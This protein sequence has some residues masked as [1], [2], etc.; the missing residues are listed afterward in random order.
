MDKDKPTTVAMTD[1]E[2][3][4]KGFSIAVVV[5][6]LFG[7][8]ALTTRP[9]LSRN[10]LIV[11]GLLSF[12]L[13]ALY[14]WGT[15]RFVRA[16]EER[17]TAELIP[18]ALVGA[19]LLLAISVTVWGRIQF[20]FLLFVL[21]GYA[22]LVYYFDKRIWSLLFLVGMVLFSCLCYGIIGGW[23][24]A[25]TELV[26]DIPWL[27]LMVTLAEGA[28]H[29]MEQRDRSA[30]MAV[31][32]K[33]AHQ[34][35]QE[36]AL[37]AEE[38]AITRERARLAHEIHDTVGHTLTALDVQLELL[39]RLSAEKTGMRQEATEK[40]RSLVKTGLTDVRRAVQALQP[41]ALENF[42][43]SEAIADLV[44]AF[45]DRSSA[46]LDYQVQGEV[47]ALSPEI[48]L[49]LYR[50]AQESLTNIQRHAPDAK[51]VSLCLVYGIDEVTFSAENDGAQSVAQANGSETGHGLAGLRQRAE[52]MGG[53]FQAESD[54]VGGSFFVQV[55]L[56]HD[57]SRSG[58]GALSQKS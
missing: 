26:D 25:L 21:I 4:R 58:H 57:L 49:L 38:L 29:R 43:V 18:V 23:D 52:I 3:R 51:R 10:A 45:E 27:A 17:G 30:D 56:H 14:A 7:F 54:E 41:I 35:L 9:P 2:A 28:I 48:A 55:R 12:M 42:S 36:Y 37:Q 19:A 53:E 50:A 39:A 11:F 20:Y 47:V 31:E 33:V 46:A 16:P 44:K 6:I 13:A 32:L 22:L 1:S 8:S 5:M 15:P 34:Q 40:A 24:T